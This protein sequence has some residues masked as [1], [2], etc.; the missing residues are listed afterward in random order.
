M[1]D[2]GPS[3][4]VLVVEDEP[5]IADM[6]GLHLRHAGYE[7]SFAL[8]AEEAKRSVGLQVPDLILLDWMLPGQ[9]GESLLRSW[10][11]ESLTKD[12]PIILLTAKSSED[13]KVAGLQAGADDYV[14]KPFSNKELMAR[15]NALLRRHRHIETA[16]VLSLGPVQLDPDA[17]EVRVAGQLVKIGPSE[18]KLLIYL[19]KHPERVHSR[20][21]LLS[22]VWRDEGSMEERTVDVH[23]KRLREVLSE[24]SFMVQTVRGA[25][26]KLSANHGS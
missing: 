8:N 2:A 14:T 9:S 11:C 3:A 19:L 12:L 13:D 26:Y 1:A 24:C 5:S 17:H 18:F 6:I 25:G 22:A 20:A 10:R 4:R 23:I 21:Q 16:A 15:I 7:V